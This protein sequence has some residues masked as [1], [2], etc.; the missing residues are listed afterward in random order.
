MSQPTVIKIPREGLYKERNEDLDPS[1]TYRVEITHDQGASVTDELRTIFSDDGDVLIVEQAPF[2]GG[3]GGSSW[4]ALVGFILLGVSISVTIFSKSFIEELGKI[5]AQKIAKALS[6]KKDTARLRV[7]SG[8]EMGPSQEVYVFVPKGCTSEDCQN[9]LRLID[10]V[11]SESKKNKPM[12]LYDPDSKRL[13]DI[14][15][16]GWEGKE[17]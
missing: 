7:T 12:F 5:M 17:K 8:S 14:T 15:P 16:S 10:S 4:A 11:I 1:K 9:M 2:E 6:D 13:I 3:G